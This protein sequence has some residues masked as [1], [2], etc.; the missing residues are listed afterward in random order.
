MKRKNKYSGNRKGI[1]RQLRESPRKDFKDLTFSDS[2]MF[3]AVLMRNKALC[4]RILETILERKV[5]SIRYV[6]A[7]KTIKEAPNAKGVR[8]DVFLEDDE[9]KLYNI[10]MQSYSEVDIA[11]RSRYYQANM[12]LAGLRSGKKSYKELNESWVIFICKKDYFG[13]N[14][15]RYTY[16]NICR[17][18]GAPLNDRAKRI[19]LNAEGTNQSISAELQELLDYVKDNKPRG[20]LTRQ[21]EEQVRRNRKDVKL[22][23]DYIPYQLEL[24]R[25]K[26]E[27]EK[28]GERR[29]EKRG[30]RN[31]KKRDIALLAKHYRLENPLLSPK[32]ATEMAKKILG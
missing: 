17:E 19:F 1:K 2:Y 4:R 6:N 18:T 13:H 3:S 14:L 20:S 25:V 11:A 32:E 24:E 29:G 8:L 16:E 31:M 23:M 30:G 9:K 12:D 5:A 21:I 22:R 7:E 28:R 15:C 26:E 27:S 10:E